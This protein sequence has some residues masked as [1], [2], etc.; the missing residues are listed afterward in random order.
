[1]KLII[2]ILFL[3]VL[4][5]IN[6]QIKLNTSFNTSHDFPFYVG[7]SSNY[8]QS[9]YSKDEINGSGNITGIKLFVSEGQTLGGL[10]DFEIYLGET[11]TVNFQNVGFIDTAVLDLVFDSTVVISNVWGKDFIQ[12]NFSVPFAYSGN[13]NLIIGIKESGNGNYYGDQHEGFYHTNGHLNTRRI[14]SLNGEVDLSSTTLGTLEDELLQITLLGINQTCPKPQEV[15]PV[16]ITQTDLFLRWEDSN[17]AGN[18]QINY[19]LPGFNNSGLGTS[20]SSTIDSALITGLSSGTRY[21]SYVRSVCGVGDTSQWVGPIYFITDCP[22]FQMPYLEDFNGTTAPCWNY[23]KGRL[24]NNTSLDFIDETGINVFNGQTEFTQLFLNE[25]EW[26]ISPSLQV[27]GSNNHVNFDIRNTAYW[28]GGTASSAWSYDDSLLLV[29]SY[30][31]GETWDRSNV[32]AQWHIN[33]L[34]AD[35]YENVSVPIPNVNGTVKFGFYHVNSLVNS[36]SFIRIDNFKLEQIPNCRRP[37]R[38]QVQYTDDESIFLTW[39]DTLAS[40]WEVEYG[41]SGFTIGTGEDTTINTTDVQLTNLLPSESYEIYLRAKCG[42]QNSAWYGGLE[43]STKCESDTVNYSFD[44]DCWTSSS[45]KISDSTIMRSNTSSWDMNI[46]GSS[47]DMRYFGVNDWL[48]SPTIS[49]SGAGD[50]LKCRLRYVDYHINEFYSW[51]IDDTL[52][53]VISTDNGKTW[54]I[55]NSL[56]IFTYTH[57]PDLTDF[58]QLYDLSSYTGDI[59]VGFYASSKNK[60][61]GMKVFLENIYIGQ[62]PTCIS[63]SNF[64][65]T[66]IE[67]NNADVIVDHIFPVQGY[68]VSIVTAGSQPN[69]N[70]AIFSNIDSIHVTGLNPGTSYHVFVRNVCAVGDTSDWQGSIYFKT[71][72][73]IETL[74]YTE[75]FSYNWPNCWGEGQ[76]ILSDSTEFTTTFSFWDDTYWGSPFGYCMWVNNFGQ[77]TENWLFTPSFDLSGSDYFMEL[78]LVAKNASQGAN[79]TWGTDDSLCLLIS[80]DNGI[81]WSNSNILETWTENS[82][83]NSNLQSFRIDLA[84]Y[85]G[86]VKFALR[87]S[88]TTNDGNL[89]IVLYG[90]RIRQKPDIEA[91]FAPEIANDVICGPDS[92]HIDSL[93]HIINHSSSLLAVVPYEFKIGSQTIKSSS[94]GVAPLDTVRVLVDGIS[95]SGQYNIEASVLFDMDVNMNNNTVST[96]QII[97]NWSYDSIQHDVTCYGEN[98]GFLAVDFTGMLGNYDFHWVSNVSNPNSP[99]LM[100]LTSGI[101]T[102]SYQDDFGCSDL[103]SFFVSQ[104]DELEVDLQ[105]NFDG[106]VTANVTGGTPPYQYQ[107]DGLGLGQTSLPF[108][109]FQEILITDA[110]GCEVEDTISA[111]AS[112]E[113]ANISE[114]INIYP[115]P[116]LN[117]LFIQYTQGLKDIRNI[118]LYD[119]RGKEV[120]I[121]ITE[122]NGEKLILDLS[123]IAVGVYTLHVKIEEGIISKKVI[124]VH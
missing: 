54:D 46:I 102:V 88:S 77:N 114:L 83:I 86:T 10:G 121:S 1:M 103:I 76:G 120:E 101:Y 109:G 21:E 39:E 90:F 82:G 115:N 52:A 19:G 37:S 91:Y 23:R 111:I 57:K 2:S 70:T 106:T 47:L 36:Y 118:A 22:S 110:N 69:S 28:N 67:A 117:K 50:F 92:R 4:G 72:C 105:D 104:P 108:V 112:L 13:D 35:K 33:H 85:S 25:R 96:N 59:K 81:T 61:G 24:E 95:A 41:L 45:G 16:L 40:E 12:I 98:D 31:D 107:W 30:D 43:A 113:S 8:F 49:L 68:E 87:A 42:N 60:D 29:V 20:I 123:S 3:F 74:P 14:S 15:K 80:L 51:G 58:Y 38:L 122:I 75:N 78:N 44:D 34:P 48:I 63:P 9:I 64:M 55:N 26:I 71:P 93:F 53:I 89:G 73:G 119:V 62:V 65:V 56:E 116:V 17:N 5:S 6:S 100:S 99:V 7:K 66:N 11:A 18:Y 97:S 94:I 124:V 27:S 79:Y 32:L 84:G